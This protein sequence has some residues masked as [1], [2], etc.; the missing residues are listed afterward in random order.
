MVGAEESCATRSQVDDKKAE[1]CIGPQG[2]GYTHGLS[3]TLGWDRGLSN[4]SHDVL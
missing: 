3:L 2:R 4:V 1:L